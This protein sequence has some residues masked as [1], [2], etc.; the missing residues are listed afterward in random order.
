MFNKPT[1]YKHIKAW[2]QFMGSYD[3]FIEMEQFNA[4]ADDAPLNAIYK[5]GDKWYTFDEI[6]N[7]ETRWLIEGRLEAMK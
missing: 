5:S 6:E 4:A 3:S 7:E 2:G 1:D